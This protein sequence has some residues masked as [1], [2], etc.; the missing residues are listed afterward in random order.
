MPRPRAPE[1]RRRVAQQALRDR[2]APGPSAAAA[3]GASSTTRPCSSTTPCVAICESTARSWVMNTSDIPASLDEREHE[4]EDLGLDRHVQRG[5][6]LVGDQQPRRARQ[7]DRDGDPLALPAGELVRVAPRRSTPGRAA[8]PARPRRSRARRPP[9]SST[10]L[11][12]RIDSAIWRPT[13]RIGFRAVRGS[14]KT[15]PI[16]SPRSAA[17]SRVR[18]PDQLGAVPPHAAARGRAVREQAEDREGRQRLA[19][20]GF[21]DQAD[22]C[23]VRHRRTR[24]RRRRGGRRCR[25]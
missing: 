5:G 16:S 21:A 11:W 6:R 9:P 24:C 15:M 12:M 19:R 8:R 23:A 1:G 4:L 14:W 17:S 13:V 10:S 7:R 3:T 22:A 20:A 25:S 2:R 18:H